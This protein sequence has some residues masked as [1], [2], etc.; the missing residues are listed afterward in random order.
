MLSLGT[1]T[2]QCLCVTIESVTGRI[3]VF[4]SSDYSMSF[5]ISVGVNV[6]VLCA[7]VMKYSVRPFI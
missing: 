1:K 6:K 3:N 7:V 4:L 5:D 2:C